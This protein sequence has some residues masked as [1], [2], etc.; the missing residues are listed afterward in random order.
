MSRNIVSRILFDCNKGRK[1]LLKV[2]LLLLFHIKN[3]N[4]IS[5]TNLILSKHDRSFER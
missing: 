4:G 3:L 5:E 1:S 2:L